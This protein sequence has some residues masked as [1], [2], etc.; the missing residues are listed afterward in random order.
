MDSSGVSQRIFAF[1]GNDGTAGASAVVAQLK[2]DL[3]GL[4]RGPRRSGQRR[5]RYHQRGYSHRRLRQQL[6]RR[7]SEHGRAFRVR[8]GAGRYQPYHY[9]IGFTA[10]PVMNA[11]PTGSIAR[12]PT[13]AGLACAPYTEIFNPNINLGW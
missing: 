6:L 4:V 3:T 1:S 12:S 2:M 11:T 5:Q 13:A 7:D 10:Y 9:W 8:N